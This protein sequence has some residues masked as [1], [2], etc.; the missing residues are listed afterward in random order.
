M[1]EER[2]NVV[3]SHGTCKRD[4]YSAGKCIFHC[5]KNEGNGWFNIQDGRKEWNKDQLNR[6]WAEIR[7]KYSDLDKINHISGFIFPEFEN[8]GRIASSNPE[9]LSKNYNFWI[10]GIPT[11]DVKFNELIFRDCIFTGKTRF[12]DTYF[13]NISFQGCKF[14]EDFSISES[15]FSVIELNRCK[16]DGRMFIVN[17]EFDSIEATLKLYDV[18]IN[19]RLVIRKIINSKMNIQFNLC[20]FNE[21]SIGDITNVSVNRLR[22]E[23]T[24]NYSKTF[25]IRDLAVK[26]ELAI[27]NMSVDNFTFIGC[28]FEKTNRILLK[29]I[30]LQNVKFDNINWGE[31]NPNHIDANRDVIRQLKHSNDQQSNYI[32][33]NKFY[34][35]EMEKYGEEVSLFKDFQEWLVFMISKNLSNFSQDWVLPILWFGFLSMFLFNI[36]TIFTVSSLDYG[37]LWFP[38]QMMFSHFKWVFVLHFSFL[39]VCL[40]NSKDYYYFLLKRILG[41]ANLA[42]F[43]GFI[44]VWLSFPESLI[45]FEQF[46]MF[47]NPLQFSLPKNYNLLYL[48]LMILHRLFTFVIGYHLVTALRFHTRRK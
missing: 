26:N 42:A 30:S 24:Y 3:C 7:E 48:V 38:I 41:Y 32:Q 1:D 33:A 17:S 43:I 27:D 19:K 40:F 37:D 28:D 6:F 16:F 18:E 11:H 4:A 25:Q 9:I 21:D 47:A 20:H 2:D 29:N 34:S 13:M 14:Y 10:K 44:F 23:D 36:L 35:L 12:N 39:F 5:D 46:I 22:F 15:T 45:S 8:Y 31:I